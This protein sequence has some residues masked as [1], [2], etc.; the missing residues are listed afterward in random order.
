[1]EISIRKLVET[2]AELT[3]FEGEIEWDTSKPDGQPRRQLDI[4][5]AKDCF[6]WEASTEF[7]TGLDHTV[8]WY[9]DHRDVIVD[10]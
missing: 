10:E 8:M 4:S 3:G 6:D 5:R 9:E 2:I 1:M 7:E